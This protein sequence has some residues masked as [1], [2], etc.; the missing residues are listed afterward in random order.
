MVTGSTVPISF[1]AKQ[2]H[3]ASFHH[4]WEAIAATLL[5][6]YWKDGKTKPADILSKHWEFSTVCPLLKPNL[7]WHGDMA[8]S[9]SQLNRCDKIPTKRPSSDPDGQGRNWKSSTSSDRA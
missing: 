8:L 9:R 1:V 5:V 3:I 4:I 6:F 2:H 7:F